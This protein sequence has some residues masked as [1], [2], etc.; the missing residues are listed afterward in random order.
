MRAH[1]VDLVRHQL[2]RDPRHL[3]DEIGL[4]NVVSLER[5]NP[6]LQRLAGG[7][8]LVDRGTERRIDLVAQ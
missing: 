1:D 8:A 7:V 5:E 3:P 4:G 6:G 2:D